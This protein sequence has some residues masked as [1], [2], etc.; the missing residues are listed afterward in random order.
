MRVS[1]FTALLLMLVALPVITSAA[2]QAS[3]TATNWQEINFGPFGFRIPPGMTNVAVRGVD[4]IVGGCVSSNMILIF[5]Y[6]WFSG[7]S[8]KG[9]LDTWG[10]YP[11]F[12]LT[13]TTIDGYRAEVVSYQVSARYCTESEGKTNVIRVVF[14]KI[15]KEGG[16]ALS[17]TT[18]CQSEADYAVAQ[19]IFE[20][21][22]FKR[23]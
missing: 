23:D 21:I 13:D 3:S 11:K 20:S 5:N 12:K 4:S 1:S 6:G 7:G 17:M 16:T 18:Y 15:R 10:R 8:F 14:P 22:R 2:D 19:R 9:D